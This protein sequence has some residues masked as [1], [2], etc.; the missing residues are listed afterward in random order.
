MKT[1]LLIFVVYSVVL[2][3]CEH[4]KVHTGTFPDEPVNM[5]NI[6]SGYDDYNSTIPIL[7]NTGPLCFSSNRN[8]GGKDFD[9]IYILLDVLMSK[10]TGVLTVDKS[11]N[12][13]PGAACIN[14][15][16][17]YAVSTVNTSNDELGPLLIQLGSFVE[18]S[19]YECPTNSYLLLYANNKSGNLDIKFT[20]N[21][22]LHYYKAAKDVAFLN[23][24]KDDAYPTINIDTSA[25]YFC[26]NRDGKFHIYEADINKKNGLLAELNDSTPRTITRVSAL[27]SD[28][29][30]KCPYITGYLMV[31][32]S[33][34]PGG[35]GGYD[36]YYS[37][38][39]N[40]NWSEPVNFGDKIN[41]EYDE[42]RPVVKPFQD[43]TN[44]FMIFSSNR[45]GGKGGFDL[46]YVG[47]NK[48]TGTL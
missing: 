22:T 17:P 12:N 27:S 29:D 8:S 47:I 36:L 33:N 25:I 4:Y 43:F 24:D 10:H 21:Q 46:Y 1:L 11:D 16:L 19:E 40:G 9:L 35:Y 45:P 14:A 30:D 23:S 34:R 18:G 5:Q 37:K 38:F 13:N 48:M 28:Y 6:N 2:N 31:F 42:F 44:D 32:C 26:S 41:T 3:F 15:S 20:E 7:G 39:T